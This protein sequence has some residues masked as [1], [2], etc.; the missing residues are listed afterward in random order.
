MDDANRT[1]RVV[2]ADDHPMVRDGTQAYLE[3][4]P[5]IRVVGVAGSAAE[6]LRLVE[7]ERPD[8]LVL[9]VHLPDQSGVAV[10]RQVRARFPQTAI[11]ILTGYD[12]VGQARALRRLGVLGYLQKTASAQEIVAAVRAVAAGQHAPE[13][14]ELPEASGALTQTLT[15]R[16]YEVLRLVAAGKRNADIAQSLRLSISTVEFHVSNVLAKLEARSRAEA[17][18]IAHQHGIVSLDESCNR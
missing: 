16:E 13:G 14:A 18:A 2:L 17:I 4:E 11:L 10:T 9:D 5:G 1:I 8:V 15:A 7:A 12:N 3:G 6:T